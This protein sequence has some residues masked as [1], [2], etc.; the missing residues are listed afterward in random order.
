MKKEESNIYQFIN[1]ELQKIESKVSDMFF[2]FRADKIPFFK[3]I[4]WEKFESKKSDTKSN[5]DFFKCFEKYLTLGKLSKAYNTIKAQTTI[6][7]YLDKFEKETG[8]VITFEKLND[9]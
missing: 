6:K 9:R 5:F 4:F 3:E 8:F 7:Y 1:D 2:F